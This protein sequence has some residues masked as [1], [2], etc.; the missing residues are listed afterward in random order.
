MGNYDTARYH[1]QGIG[2]DDLG[3]LHLTF[4]AE[5]G[6]CG[7]ARGKV[8]ASP[9]SWPAPGVGN[10]ASELATHCRGGR[11]NSSASRN[12]LGG[13]G[14]STR[15]SLSRLGHLLAHRVDQRI[16]VVVVAAQ[17]GGVVL[18]LRQ[19][20]RRALGD[21]VDDLRSLAGLLMIQ[22]TLVGGLFGRSTTVDTTSLSSRCCARPMVKRTPRYSPSLAVMLFT[23]TWWNS[24]V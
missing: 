22:S 13:I 2:P 4:P 15:A 19:P 18:A 8:V 10:A 3:E 5:P 21:D 14:W 9:V 6:D 23:S 7:A 11:G 20:Q 24:S 17:I 1:T 12:V 16:D